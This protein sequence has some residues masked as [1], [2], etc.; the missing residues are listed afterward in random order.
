[1]GLV[2]FQEMATATND[3]EVGPAQGFLVITHTLGGSATQSTLCLQ[4]GLGQRWL[5]MANRSFEG[6]YAAG[7][8]IRHIPMQAAEEPLVLNIIPSAE[9]LLWDRLHVGI[10]GYQV[11][12]CVGNDLKRRFGPDP[13]EPS[14]GHIHQPIVSVVSEDALWVG[15]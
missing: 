1:V 8:R 13:A 14:K 9:G 15:E 11:A 7:K 10:S 6:Q 2:P 3:N 4:N 5:D 12:W